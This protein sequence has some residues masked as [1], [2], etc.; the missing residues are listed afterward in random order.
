MEACFRSD[1]YDRFSN[2]QEGS[3]SMKKSLLA[4]LFLFAGGLV[5]AA[6]ERAVSPVGLPAGLLPHVVYYNSFDCTSND[7]NPEIDRFGVE[8][9]RPA[10]IR[11]GEGIGG[12]ALQH[13]VPSHAHFIT[14]NPELGM[15]RN[16]TFS[17]WFRYEDTP[18]S[19]HRIENITEHSRGIGLHIFWFPGYANSNIGFYV[20]LWNG[21]TLDVAGVAGAP[22]AAGGVAGEFAEVYPPGE[23]HHAVIASNGKRIMWFI[24]GQKLFEHAVAAPLEPPLAFNQCTVGHHDTFIDEFVVFDITL[25]EEAITEY[26]DSVRNHLA[27]EAM[28]R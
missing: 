5:A 8:I 26:F 1:G 3:R 13:T 18:D 14:Q 15:D 4:I 28:L 10:S 25:T 23:W 24:E 27:R 22:R 17:I 20:N 12:A 7:R 21:L 19:W 6:G 11:M 9:S 2:P 16:R